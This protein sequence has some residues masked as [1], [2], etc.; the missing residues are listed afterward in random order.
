MAEADRRGGDRVQRLARLVQRPPRQ[1]HEDRVH[2]AVERDAPQRDPPQERL[3]VRDGRRAARTE[4]AWSTRAHALE[5]VLAKL[6]RQ[7]VEEAP[8]GGVRE[9]G[10]HP[11]RRRIAAIAAG[12]PWM[13]EQ[14]R[15]PGDRRAAGECSG[16]PAGET[17]GGESDG[18]SSD[19]AG[20]GRA[21][22]S[23]A[24]ASRSVQA[25][26][27][28]DVSAAVTHDD[29][30]GVEERSV[31]VHRAAA[32]ELEGLRSGARRV[33][34]DH[35]AAEVTRPRRGEDG[36]SLRRP[37]R[38]SSPPAMRI[39]CC[40]ARMPRRSSSSMTAPRAA[41]R[42]SRRIR[43]AGASGARRR[44]P[45]CPPGVTRSASAGPESG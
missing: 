40:S 38:R 27:R 35:R 26:P 22:S 44:S 30:V 13:V 24:Q 10:D 34:H 2:R 16:H 36:L 39:V 8:H 43:E 12:R 41:R 4:A 33:V 18:A 9:G 17:P 5:R 1:R 45:R 32:V 14:D 37:A 21:M 6:P 42:G 29:Q 25:P 23:A 7:R 19:G 31:D 28:S 11:G 15:H 3:G 20:A